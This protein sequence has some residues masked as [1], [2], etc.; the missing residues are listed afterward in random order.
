MTPL[1]TVS[2]LNY[3]RTSSLEQVLESVRMQSYPAIETIVVDNGSGAE[4]VEHLR[5]SFPWVKLV[6]LP[7]NLGAPARNAGLEAAQGGIV[8]TLDNDVYFSG[9]DDVARIVSAFE[10]H[11]KAGCL[12]FRVCHPASGTLHARDWAHPRPWRQ[13]EHDEFETHYITE[14]A[15]AFR[16][17]IFDTIEPYWNALFIGHEGFDLALRLLDGGYEVWYVP[18]VSV[19]HGH[20]QET[21]TSW[22]PFYFNTKNLF[23]VIYRNYPWPRGIAFLCPRLAVLGFYAAKNGH[24]SRFLAGVRDGVSALATVRPVR[25]PVASHTLR[26]LAS[27]KHWQPGAL[28]RAMRHWQKVEF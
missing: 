18:E 23:Q 4:T 27:L 14:G 1:V 25:R 26:K 10:R 9:P 19:W 28:S 3:R 20:S 22:R 7:E 24:F 6:A 2:V 16:R 11:P 8:V 13:A 12:A 21:R 15:C 17:S 5:N